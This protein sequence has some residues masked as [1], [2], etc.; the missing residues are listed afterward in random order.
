MLSIIVPIF[1]SESTHPFRD[2]SDGDHCPLSYP[3]SLIFHCFSPSRHSFCRP[4]SKL[5]FANSSTICC[6]FLACSCIAPSTP[7]KPSKMVSNRVQQEFTWTRKPREVTRTSQSDGNRIVNL[8]PT[9]PPGAQ[10]EW[11]KRRGA[12]IINSLQRQRSQERADQY[13]WTSQHASL[14]ISETQSAWTRCPLQLQRKKKQR[15]MWTELSFPVRS[16]VLARTT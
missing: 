3:P 2:M 14:R 13:T 10:R 4:C 16:S 8:T 12:A 15:Q 5:I 1:L 9:T 11:N 6:I 7:E